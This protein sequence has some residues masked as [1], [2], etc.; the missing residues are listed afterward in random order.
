MQ[1]TNDIAPHMETLNRAL[2][3]KIGTEI[4]PQDLQDELKKYIEYGVPPEQAVKT[5][6][7]HH[8]VASQAP[9]AAR[10]DE[11]TMVA[12]VP[13]NV[14]FVNLKVRL[15][16]YNTR[17]VMARGEEKEIIWGLVGD[18]TGSL[19]YT[20]WRAMEGLEKG[21]V[22]TVSGAYTK[23]FRNEVQ[24]NFGDRTQIE[25]AE[26]DIPKT[27][28]TFNDVKVGDLREGLRALRL[29]ARILDVTA[30]EI[31]V[32]GSPK[33]IYSGTLA[34]ETGK[35]EFTS[36]HDHGLEADTGVTIEGGYIRAFRGQPQFNFDQEA[37]I[38]KATEELPPAEELQSSL[39]STI[40]ELLSKGGGND[41]LVLGTLLEV[42][43]G[44]GLIYRD[45]ET[46]RVTQKSPEAIPDLRIKAVLD[47]GTGA[48]NLIVGKELT[49]Q[50]LGKDLD[51]CQAMAQ[52]AFRLEVVQEELHEKLAGR[53]YMVRGNAFSDD[54]GMTFLVKELK[55]DEADV[56]AEAKAYLEEE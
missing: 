23:E 32:Q 34:D 25:K 15:I 37:T 38:T 44:S 16:T 24:V 40:G 19:P 56:Q 13:A 48:V 22:I 35:V 52:E 29:T 31:N 39:R 20:S 21:D 54:Y 43:P 47:D 4:D 36:W 6:L 55:N 50:L 18:E 33:T 41:V 45:P 3:D 42:R 49:E 30:R 5:I 12:D 10:S 28:T 7:R 26:D 51:A 46:N 17:T 53:V 2:E 11:R 9:P 8:G 14:P 27:P 1:T